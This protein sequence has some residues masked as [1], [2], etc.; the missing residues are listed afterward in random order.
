MC[1]MMKI[2]PTGNATNLCACAAHTCLTYIALSLHTETA[3]T[4]VTSLLKCQSKFYV[5]IHL[6]KD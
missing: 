6:H 4:W 1:I 5:D 3:C 2:V